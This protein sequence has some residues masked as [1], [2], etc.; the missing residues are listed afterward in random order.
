MLRE[1]FSRVPA[2]AFK[3]LAIAVVLLVIVAIYGTFDPAAHPFPPCPFRTL[4]GLM[5]PGCGAQR[6]IH[7]VLNGHPAQAMQLHPLILPG[8]VYITAGLVLP[9]LR[10]SLYARLR[11]V[12]FGSRAAWIALAVIMTFWIGR[13]I[14]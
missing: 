5:C 7:Q 6:A 4:T 1:A 2:E 3:R 14:S 11:P 9:V 8:I 12:F 10:P 13:N